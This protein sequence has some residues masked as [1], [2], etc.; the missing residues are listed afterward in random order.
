MQKETNSILLSLKQHLKKVSDVIIDK[1]DV[2]YFDYPLH[3]NVG[4]LLIYA[5]T[6]AFFKHENIHIRLRRCL[7]A[8]DI[9]EVKKYINKNTTILCHGGGNFGDLYPLIHQLREDLITHFPDNRIVVLPQ[10]AYFSDETAMKKSAALFAKHK[11]CYLFARDAFTQEIMQHF[12]DKV[13]LCPDM[14]HQLYGILPICDTAEKSAVENQYK[15]TLY[16][17]R[18]DIEASQLE[19]EIQ[20]N[21]PSLQNVKDWDD[22]LSVKDLKFELYLGRLSKLANKL[23][24]AF[25]KNRI[26]EFWYQHALNIIYRAQQQFSAYDLVVTSRLH[27]HIFSCLLGIPNQVCDNS[28][29]K[30]MRYYRQWTKDI[31][32]A[33]QYQNP[34]DSN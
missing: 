1:N 31:D 10:T 25:M 28:Y 26:N 22:L 8:F 29:G 20:S 15:K 2:L 30:N 23:N 19:K 24:L 18:K 3:L 7:P 4:D 13:E 9:N 21:L 12:S 33:T 32:Y 6:E 17:L 14:A 27:G 34:S 11:D 16:F 5:G